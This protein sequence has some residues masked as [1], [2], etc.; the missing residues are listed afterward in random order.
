LVHGFVNPK[1]IVFDTD[2]RAQITNFGRARTRIVKLLQHQ[3]SNLAEYDYHYQAPEFSRGKV[4]PTTDVYSLGC[5]AFEMLTAQRFASVGVKSPREIE[6][7]V[8][9]WVDKIVVRMLSPEPGFS[10]KDKSNPNKRYVNMEHLLRAIRDVQDTIDIRLLLPKI[11]DYFSLSELKEIAFLLTGD[12]E[13]VSTAKT[14]IDFIRQ[15]LVYFQQRGKSH[16][17]IETIRQARPNAGI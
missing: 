7:S 11:K 13:T 5:V 12:D 17:L 9:E 4:A 15:M 14:K 8:P 16:E 10:V 2:N 1:T 6:P 3:P